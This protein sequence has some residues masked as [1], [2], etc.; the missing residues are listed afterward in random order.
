M[1]NQI[2]L[3]NIQAEIK[4]AQEQNKQN[5]GRNPK[6]SEKE[7]QKLL[8][9]VQAKENETQEKV[10]KEKAAVLGTRQNEKNW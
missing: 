8:Q 10:N 1:A 3:D 6:M 7:A 5:Q 9:M 2:E 4:Q